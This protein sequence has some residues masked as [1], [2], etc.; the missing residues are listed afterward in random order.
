MFAK[1]SARI[2]RRGLN[3]YDVGKSG[4]SKQGACRLRTT[5]RAQRVGISLIYRE[6]LPETFVFA[7]AMYLCKKVFCTGFLS[8]L[9]MHANTLYFT[10]D[11]SISAAVCDRKSNTHQSNVRQLKN[12]AAVNG[13]HAGNT[14]GIILLILR[15][16]RRKRAGSGPARRG[17]RMLLPRV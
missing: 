13:H 9:K 15:R 5:Q 2:T 11:S 1:C 4:M 6:R 7:I 3:N 16:P 10:A 12:F 14:S 17:T 8:H